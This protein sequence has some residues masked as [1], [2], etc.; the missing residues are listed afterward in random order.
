[1]RR[2][3]LAVLLLVNAA[4]VG[5]VAGR[6]TAPPPATELRWSA[7]HRWVEVYRNGDLVAE[8]NAARDGAT[9]RELAA[10]L[11]ARP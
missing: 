10:A 11:D 2:Y 7:D 4:A 8:Y 3:L 1:M 6:Q 5:F 9:F